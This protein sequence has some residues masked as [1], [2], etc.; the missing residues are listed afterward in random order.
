MIIHLNPL[1]I[2]LVAI[3][4]LLLQ[5]V[6]IIIIAVI[7]SGSRSSLYAEHAIQLAT[8]KETK[9]N[10]CDCPCHSR[11]SSM[12]PGMRCIDCIGEPCDEGTV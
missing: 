7:V 12:M 8:G 3:A 9:E 6:N 5:A 10:A 11:R 1:T 2:F 4:V